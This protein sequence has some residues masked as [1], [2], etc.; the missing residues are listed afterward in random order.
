MLLL[1][2]QFGLIIEHGKREVLYY[3]RAQGFFNLPLLDLTILEGTIFHSKE[4]WHY[5]E[6]N[7]QQKINFSSTH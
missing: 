4:M 5:L 7:L 3:F 1:F 6:F 2:E